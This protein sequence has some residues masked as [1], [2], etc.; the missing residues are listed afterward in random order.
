MSAFDNIVEGI[1]RKKVGMLI[2]CNNIAQDLENKAKQ[3]AQW[4]D[5]TGH[6]RQALNGEAS[7]KGNDYVISLSHGVEYGEILEEGSKPHVIRPKNK[8]ALYWRG[9]NHPVK[10]VNHPG[11][12]GKPI[13]GPTLENNIG[14][15][16]NTVID[17]W[18]D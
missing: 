14:N 18:S 1:E 13:I 6:A 15:I 11:T 4:T 7:N 16:K 9:A 5:R 12:K 8:K 2:L 10:V 17:Y 3:N